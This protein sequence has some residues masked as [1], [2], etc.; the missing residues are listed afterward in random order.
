MFNNEINPIYNIFK[1]H[2][3]NVILNEYQFTTPKLTHGCIYIVRDPR[4]IAVSFAGHRGKSIN[5]TIDFMSKIESYFLPRN[6]HVL[7]LLTSWDTHYK[8]WMQLKVPILLIKYENLLENPRIEIK[9]IIKFLNKLLKIDK[10]DSNDKLNNICISTDLKKFI[11]YEKNFGFNEA[12]KYRS[13]FTKSG[14]NWKKNL[15]IKQINTIENYFKKT[16]QKLNYI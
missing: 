15:S 4:D 8:S 7:T 11:D 5:D 3:A 13:F 10:K 16:M 2:S 9:K 12:S 1:T 14:H 6:D